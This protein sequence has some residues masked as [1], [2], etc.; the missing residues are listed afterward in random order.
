[1]IE[2]QN[3][4]IVYVLVIFIEDRLEYLHKNDLKTTKNLQKQSLGGVL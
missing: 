1:M 4:V 3:I 2:F